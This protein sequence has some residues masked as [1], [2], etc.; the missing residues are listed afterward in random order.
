M[1]VC[2]RQIYPANNNASC[3]TESVGDTKKQPMSYCLWP[4]DD[5]F[6]QTGK[7]WLL[8]YSI[9]ACN[10]KEMCEVSFQGRTRFQQLKHFRY[11]RHSQTFQTFSDIQN[12]SEKHLKETEG[13]ERCL[14]GMTEIDQ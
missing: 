14:K 12:E 7:Q 1:R 8:L 4:T 13:D 9:T 3:D 6:K 11:E 10:I 2:V 5:L